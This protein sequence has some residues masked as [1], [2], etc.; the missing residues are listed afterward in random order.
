MAAPAT[1]HDA[2][3]RGDLQAVQAFIASGADVNKSINN[4]ISPLFIA[5]EFGYL[6]IV[7]TLIAL[8][9]MSIKQRM[10]EH[11]HYM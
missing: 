10:M 2:A 9:R 7:K 11:R 5:S 3:S 6:E 4:G 1:L 8:E